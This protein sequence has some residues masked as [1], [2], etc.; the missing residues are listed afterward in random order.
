MEVLETEHD[1]TQQTRSSSGSP[2]ASAAQLPPGREIAEGGMISQSNSRSETTLARN[3]P[4]PPERQG[5]PTAAKPSARPRPCTDSADC[6]DSAIVQGIP[7]AVAVLLNL[8][9]Y[10]VAMGVVCGV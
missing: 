2:D 7:V 6:A 3:E 10:A 1:G 8:F 4:D 5:N 9:C